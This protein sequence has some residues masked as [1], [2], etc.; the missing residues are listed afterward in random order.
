RPLLIASLFVAALGAANREFALPQIRDAISRN[1]QDLGG[2]TGK[3]CTPKYDNR[4][5]ILIS[6]Q[7]TYANQKRLSSPKFG[8][9]TGL[10]AWGPQIA[11][12]IPFSLGDTPKPP[13]ASLL[14]SV[15]QPANLA[16]L[17]SRSLDGH[18]VLFSPA[19]TPWLNAGDCFVASIV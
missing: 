1:A 12:E 2:D 19:D 3:K 10:A 13:P 9:P 16:A 4:T 11:A 7:S 8:L 6:A 17:A 5:D 14:P 15:K 18:A